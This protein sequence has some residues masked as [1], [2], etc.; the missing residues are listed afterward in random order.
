M[1]PVG[2]ASLHIVTQKARKLPKPIPTHAEA[3]Q[4]EGAG[5]PI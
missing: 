5:A 2:R 1:S 4:A 3:S